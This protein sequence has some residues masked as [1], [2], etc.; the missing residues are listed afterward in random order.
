MAAYYLD[1]SALVKLYIE[2]AGTDKLL[3]LA[4]NIERGTWAVSDLARV[5][6]RAAVGRRQREGDISPETSREIFS[7]LDQH[8]ASLYLVQPVTSSVVEE[9][10]ALLDRHPL[11]AYDSVQ[12]AGCI[13]LSRMERTSARTFVCAD[14]TLLQAATAEGLAVFNPL[15]GDIAD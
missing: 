14:R 4:A 9:A 8:I 15:D 5:E 10:I 11:R 12:L 3:G 6:F 13:V 7:E 1:T 2:E